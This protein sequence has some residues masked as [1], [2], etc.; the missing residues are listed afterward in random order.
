MSVW[1]P[2][3][4]ALVGTTLGGL[5]AYWNSSVQWKR[6]LELDKN[7]LL[8]EKLERICTITLEVDRTLQKA[9]SDIFMNSL[10]PAANPLPGGPR[11]PIAELQMVVA[12]YFPE[13]ENRAKDVEEARNVLGNS[14][15]E[16]IQIASKS[17]DEAKKWRSES[18]DAHTGVSKA[19]SELIAEA[20]IISAKL[21]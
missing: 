14:I 1:L 8:R 4:A 5:I 10:V 12:L 17:E 11:V 9:W 2:F 20:S 19:C 15:S 13:L 21:R 7:Q 16:G 6:Q 3:V 18:L